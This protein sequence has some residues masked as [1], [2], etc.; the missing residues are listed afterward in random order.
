[1]ESVMYK[2]MKVMALCALALVSSLAV[3]GD[4]VVENAWIREAP[5]GAMAMGGFMT[6]HNHGA[7]DRML[8]A[9]SSPAFD[10]VMLHQTVMDGAMAKMVH[11]H[12]ITLPA[13]GSLLFEP[14]GYHLMMMKP[15]RALKAGEMV[16]VTLTFK[17]GDSLEVQHQVRAGM[18][19]MGGMSHGH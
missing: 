4:V 17:D 6:L 5:P 19:G 3:A 7:V 15:K 2:M 14:S 11:Q 13:N 16:S 9:A 10:S 8:V 18:G 12:M 1:M